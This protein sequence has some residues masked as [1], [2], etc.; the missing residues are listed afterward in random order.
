MWCDVIW[1]YRCLHFKVRPIFNIEDF[2]HEVRGRTFIRNIDKILSDYTA[3]NPRRKYSCDVLGFSSSAFLVSVFYWMWR[4]ISRWLM[5][6]VS[7]ECIASIFKCRNWI[8]NNVARWITMVSRNPG[9]RHSVTQRHTPDERRSQSVSVL[10]TAVRSR[11]IYSLFT[12]S[13][14]QNYLTE[15]NAKELQ[16]KQFK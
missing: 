5:P 6:S 13:F 7:W 10:N 15:F 2:L 8:S 12:F 11:E 1:L 4:R 3:S 9:N 16:F 14:R